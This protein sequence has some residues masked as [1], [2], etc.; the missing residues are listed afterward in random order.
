MDNNPT[1]SGGNNKGVQ[2]SP[3]HMPQLDSL[4]ALA[5]LGVAAS[6]WLRKDDPITFLGGT[7]VQL[8]F[9]LSGFLITGILLDYR[10]VQEGSGDL[11]SAAST[12]RT[13]YARRFLRILPLYYGVIVVAAILNVGPIR[14]L[15]PWHVAYVPNFLYAIHKPFAGD[16]F[17]HFWSLGVEEQFYFVWPF[18]IFFVS[19]ANL[20]WWISALIVAA[21]LFRIGMEF[22][23]PEFNR[24]NY[25]PLSCGDSLGVG[26]CLAFASRNGAFLKWEPPRLARGLGILGL[27]GGLIVGGFML[28][29]G[30]SFWLLTIGHTCLILVYGWLVF[31]AAKGFGSVAGRVLMRPE[32]RFL[33]KISYGLYVF[34]HFFTH[35]SFRGF[36]ERLGVPSSLAENALAQSFVRLLLTILLATVSWYL[37]ENPLNNLKR[38]FT[39]RK[40]LAQAHDREELRIA[41]ARS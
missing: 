40:K 31:R 15:W 3:P 34:H 19:L 24:V 41:Q 10:R 33:E 20:Q 7:G 32:L 27:A 9:V 37:Y 2:D 26:A 1:S 17:T 13:F 23:F 38:H 25:F 22:A 29:R 30:E 14:T 16:P 8:F 35:V 28:V 6:H 39:L 36:L 21:P 11:L 18:L 5:F 12:L 4:R